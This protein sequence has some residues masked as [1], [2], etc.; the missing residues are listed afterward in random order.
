[1]CPNLVKRRIAMYSGSSSWGPV[2]DQADQVFPPNA[3]ALT[4]SVVSE[5]ALALPERSGR[6]D[7]DGESARRFA[8][9]LG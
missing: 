3:G 9:H 2:T 1:M 4:R 7:D 6:V 5:A 8:R